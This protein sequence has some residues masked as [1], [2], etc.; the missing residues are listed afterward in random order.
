ML[1]NLHNEWAN[2]GITKAAGDWI[3][4]LTDD[5]LDEPSPI[6]M[7][8][9]TDAM[10]AAYVGAA[11]SM[12]RQITDP[13]PLT[14]YKREIDDPTPNAMLLRSATAATDYAAARGA[15]MVGRKYDADGELVD[16]PNADWAITSTVRDIIRY[17]VRDAVATHRDVDLLAD[18][19]TDTGA[20]S[21]YR[22]EMIART[23]TSLAMNQGVLE[24]GRQAE[25]A[26]M[27][28][29]KVWTLGDNPCPLC[30]D[31]PT[32]YLWSLCRCVLGSFGD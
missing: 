32:L 19:L 17:E 7:R 6:M 5:A 25:A 31:A 9:I 27:K 22:A 3:D 12:I 29:Q 8:D 16:N 11:D 24:A 21:D 13:N 23:E 26:G 18:H 15:E 2:R 4:A 30:E 28:L 14:V 1:H 20:F 10:A